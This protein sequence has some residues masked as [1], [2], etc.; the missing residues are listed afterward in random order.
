M[1][2]NR[3]PAI[4][5]TAYVEI[6]YATLQET[7]EVKIIGSPIVAPTI[8]TKVPRGK[9]EITYTAELFGILEKLGNKK[10]QI[11]S[12][13]L[14]QKDGNNSINTTIR[15]IANETHSSTKT[16]NDTIQILRE[17]GLLER[18]HSTYMLSPRLMVKGSQ[19]REAYL[20]RKYEEMTPKAYEE[21]ENA[22]DAVVDTQ[23]S[24]TE[25]G[26]IVQRARIEGSR[27]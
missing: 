25:Q 26:E 22:I 11:F 2:A 3:P 19:L 8:T 21:Y 6:D 13:L 27:Q 9:F 23:Y 14:D 12:Y 15:E 1:S 10:I 7:G 17:A 16:V 20:M 24:F 18:K 4:Q 5:K